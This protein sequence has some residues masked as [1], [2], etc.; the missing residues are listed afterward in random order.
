[1]RNPMFL[2]L[3]STMALPQSQDLHKE[4]MLLFPCQLLM[5]WVVSV[6]ALT[7]NQ[8][9][10]K[11][12]LEQVQMK[13]YSASSW[14]LLL[15]WIGLHALWCFAAFVTFKPDRSL[16]QL[17]VVTS[18]DVSTFVDLRLYIEWCTWNEIDRKG[19]ERNKMLGVLIFAWK[20]KKS[21]NW[22][23]HYFRKADKLEK[24]RLQHT[25]VVWI[26]LQKICD[27]PW[28]YH[29][30]SGIGI[31]YHPPPGGVTSGF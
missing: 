31:C 30:S 14:L 3:A 6:E 8:I 18:S 23:G 25:K 7:Q 26:F 12:H 22:T 29:G 13:F 27:H 16:P 11:P 24:T 15:L 19:S 10:A 28:N 5:L 17:Q 21:W 2:L 1:M 20:E 9:Q 4:L